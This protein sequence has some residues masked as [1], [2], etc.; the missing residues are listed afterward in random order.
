MVA[1]DVD[2]K[3]LVGWPF[4]LLAQVPFAGEE[5][6]VAMLLE[7]L[8]EGDFLEWQTVLILRVKEGVGGAVG[9]AGDPVR[10]IDPHRVFP[11]HDARPG[12]ATNRPGGIALREAHTRAGQAVDVGSLVER[13][14]VGSD[15]RPAHVVNKEE[16]KVGLFGGVKRRHGCDK[17][18]E[19]AEA[20]RV[21]EF[22]CFHFSR[23]VGG[24]LN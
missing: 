22:G 10:D 13:A 12:R 15:I 5:S 6:L 18:A 2:V 17:N 3:A 21:V 24:S 14:T 20:Q 1:A 9:L 8:G 4:A 23:S 11:C 19:G 7:C 16:Q